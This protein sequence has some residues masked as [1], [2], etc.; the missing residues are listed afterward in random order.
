MKV[1]QISRGLAAL[2]ATFLCLA[3]LA[4]DEAPRARDLGIPFDGTPGPL[5]AI[6]AERK[7][8]SLDAV[9]SPPILRRSGRA[10][11]GGGFEIRCRGDSTGGSNPSSSA[12]ASG[13]KLPAV[14]AQALTKASENVRHTALSARTEWE[15]VLGAVRRTGGAAWIE[16][17]SRLT[18]RQI[19][20][21]FFHQR[22]AVGARTA[23]IAV[24]V[25]A[26]ASGHQDQHGAEEEHG[27]FE[28]RWLRQPSNSFA[29]S[30]H[31]PSV[32]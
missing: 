18:F 5:N 9:L 6:G 7:G 11:E 28:A 17:S 20:H 1:F 26:A 13:L 2:A 29:R 27:A 15:A 12:K 23:A 14:G 19:R 32:R 4:D 30:L 22:L 3:A 31:A 10:V 16:R 25:R 24:T 8:P 21:G